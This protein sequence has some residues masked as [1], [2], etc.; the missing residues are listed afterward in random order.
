MF[1]FSCSTV[2]MCAVP[3]IDSSLVVKI[4]DASHV[5][6]AREIISAMDDNQVQQM[7]EMSS[8]VQQINKKILRSA[9][10]FIGAMTHSSFSVRAAHRFHDFQRRGPPPPLTSNSAAFPALPCVRET[11]FRLPTRC[12][13]RS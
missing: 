2:R 3:E 11:S 7:R 13:K 4:D 8:I 10:G 9:A 12:S 5:A 1:L 6:Y